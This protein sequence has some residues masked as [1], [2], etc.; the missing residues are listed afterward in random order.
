M[1]PRA[2]ARRMKP[3]ADASKMKPRADA[4]KMNASGR[5]TTMLRSFTTRRVLALAAIALAV[6]ALPQAA[7]AQKYPE[8]P[9]RLVLPLGA[10]GVGDITPRIIPERLRAKLGQRLLCLN[11]PGPG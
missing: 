11:K 10:A 7:S 8:R 9:V 4:R 3:R 2:D 6:V 5:L 1:G